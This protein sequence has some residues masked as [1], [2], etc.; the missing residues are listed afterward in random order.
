MPEVLM[1]S[2]ALLEVRPTARAKRGIIAFATRERPV[3]NRCFSPA[4]EASTRAEKRDT[5]Q[6]GSS[7][8]VTPISLWACELADCHHEPSEQAAYIRQFMFMSVLLPIR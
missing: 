7:E 3:E 2:C 5:E 8:R 6:L 4:P 1:H